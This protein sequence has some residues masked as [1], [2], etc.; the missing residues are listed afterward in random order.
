MG[1]KKRR[2]GGRGVRFAQDRSRET[3]R[4][5]LDAALEV[6]AEKGY[7]G[8]TVAE[9]ISRAGIGHGT[10]WLYFHNKED[11]L[12]YLLQEMVDEFEAFDWYRRGDASMISMRSLQEVEEIIRAVMEIFARYSTIHPL[13]VRAAMDSEEFWEALEDLNQPFVR[14]V[15]MKLREHLEK[16]LCGDL[17]PEVTARIIVN[18]LEYTNLQWLKERREAERDALIHNLSVIIHR[19]LNHA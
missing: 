13:I 17:D 3:Q 15:E 5:I 11:L 12:R 18:M 6:F 9:I 2:A 16:G 7:N 14:I 8:T 4:R 10:F 19:T 1:A